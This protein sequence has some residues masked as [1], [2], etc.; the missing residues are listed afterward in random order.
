MSITAAL[1]PIIANAKKRPV[2]MAIKK[3][4]KESYK[5]AYFKIRKPKFISIYKEVFY[6][7]FLFID[8]F[9]RHPYHT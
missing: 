3:N 9:I 7:C 5:Q 4:H 8:D 1:N 2:P 6:S